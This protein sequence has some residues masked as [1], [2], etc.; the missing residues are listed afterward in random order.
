[1]S[2]LTPPNPQSNPNAASTSQ[3]AAAAPITVKKETKK[4]HHL[5]TETD[6]LFAELR[7]LNFSAV[8]KR[9]SKEARRLDENYRV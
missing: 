5:T 6:P 7:D 4:K 1:M 8:G 3:A 9:L 2:L